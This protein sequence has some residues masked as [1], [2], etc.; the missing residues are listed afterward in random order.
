M[1]ETITPGWIYVVSSEEHANHLV[2]EHRGK[3]RLIVIV[4][5][6]REFCVDLEIAI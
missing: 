5:D 3:P 2:Y 4:R 6:V 1:F